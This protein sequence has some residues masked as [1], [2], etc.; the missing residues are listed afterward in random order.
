MKRRFNFET[1]VLI[2]FAFAATV[3]VIIALA[4]VTWNVARDAE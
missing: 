3:L 2:T 1:N 4:G